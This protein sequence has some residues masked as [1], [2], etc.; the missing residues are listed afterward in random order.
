M[1]L[2]QLDI[3]IGFFWATVW[4]CPCYM[5]ALTVGISIQMFRINDLKT[6]ASFTFL[7]YI[8]DVMTKASH[9]MGMFIKLSGAPQADRGTMNFCPLLTV[10]VESAHIPALPSVCRLY[11]F[12][13]YSVYQG[14]FAVL[15]RFGH[16]KSNC[17]LAHFLE[18]L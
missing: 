13:H 18:A 15:F 16:H 10:I 3:P 1:P 11:A 2:G 8:Q 7:F 14:L 5:P 17:R 9:K 12:G 6:K 4:L